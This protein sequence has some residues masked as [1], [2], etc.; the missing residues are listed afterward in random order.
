[1]KIGA[2]RSMMP[3]VGESKVNRAKRPMAESK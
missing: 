3:S 1:M 2:A